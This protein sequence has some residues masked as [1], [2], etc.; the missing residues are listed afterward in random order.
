MK[1]PDR[2]RTARLVGFDTPETK[3]PG[4]P[5]EKAL[6]D[7]ATARLR[8]IVK[9]ADITMRHDG[10]DKYGRELVR[11]SADGRDVGDT[12]IREGLALAY[13]GGGRVNWCERL[14]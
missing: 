10:H 5:G 2:K 11:L 9:G 13:R 4:C 8:Q 12:L 7:K 3:D 14:N 1:C 6:G